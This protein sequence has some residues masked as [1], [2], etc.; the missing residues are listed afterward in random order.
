MLTSRTSMAVP[1]TLEPNRNV[2]PSSGCTRMTIA[3]VPSSSVMVASNG[4]CGARLK[5]RAI[6]V[7]RRP[8]RFPVRR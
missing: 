1:G 2:T 3:L 7:T 4:R 6:S 8:N 5:T